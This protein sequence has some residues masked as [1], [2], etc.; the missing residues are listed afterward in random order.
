M[1]RKLTTETFIQKARAKHGDRYDYSKVVYVNSSAKVTIICKVHGEFLQN[2]HNHVMGKGCPDCAGSKHL[3]T[4]KFIQKARAKH[5]DRYDYSKVAYISSSV[6]VEIVC[7]THG[8]FL[9]TPP[10][11]FHGKGCAKCAG[12]CP[13]TADFIEKAKAVHGTDLYG[14]S[15]VDYVKS[16]AKVKIICKVHGEFLQT[17]NRHLS[18]SG[19]AQCAGN[20]QLTSQEFIE[21]ATLKHDGKY[22]Y[23]LVNYVQSHSKVKIICKEHGIF[24]QTPDNHSHGKGC[25]D[26]GDYGYRPSKPGTL[27]YVRFD[28]PGL[29]LWK[30]GIT[31]RTVAE[32]FYN[33][34][35]DPIILWE[36]RWNDGS[37][38]EELEEDVL[39]DPRYDAYRYNGPAVLKSGSTECFTIDIM[40]LGYSRNIGRMAA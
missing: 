37:I 2:P 6:K 19:C 5:G 9:Q 20:T 27:Y 13:T 7:K 33:F 3:T 38:A 14:Y 1:P 17:P 25:P 4:E 35:V 18:G 10:N 28:L 39:N 31:N 23:S 21:K 40:A 8:S 16:S 34:G 24:L 32:R 15:L 29:K 11:H 22:D 26:C 12:K 30:I 36:R